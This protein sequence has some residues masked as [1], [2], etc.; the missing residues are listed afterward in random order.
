MAS[1]KTKTEKSVVAEEVKKLSSIDKLF[2]AEVEK[3]PAKDLFPQYDF[4]SYNNTIVK[5]KTEDK[6]IIVNNSSEGYLLISNN[7][8]FPKLEEGLKEMGKFTVEREV[9]DYSSFFVNYHFIDKERKIKIDG[10]NVELYPSI[11]IQNSYNSRY[12][13]TIIPCFY[14]KSNGVVLCLPIDDSEEDMGFN[15]ILSH[16]VGNSEMVE[17]ALE[18]IHDFLESSEEIVEAYEA[19]LKFKVNELD[20]DVTV[21]KILRGAKSLISYKDNIVEYLKTQNLSDISMFDIYN[22]IIF[23][24]QPENNEKITSDPSARRKTDEKILDYIFKLVED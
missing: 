16:C 22:A 15:V 20:I 2:F 7:D 9:R 5:V 8:I 23:M 11:F 18:G 21:E 10:T 12:L 24:A 13:F 4:N 17:E 1:R 14:N 6:E 3:I 19:L